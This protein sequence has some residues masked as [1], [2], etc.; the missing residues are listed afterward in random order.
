MTNLDFESSQLQL[1]TDA[2]RAGPGSPEWRAAMEAVNVTAGETGG[3]AGN[4]EREYKL[5]YAARERLASGRQYR[6]VRAGAGFTRKVFDAIEQEDDAAGATPRALPA[7]NLIAAV[8][9]LVILG[10]LAI[11]AWLIIPGDNSQQAANDLSQTY[12]V[13]K[14]AETTFDNGLGADWISF[15]KL[16]VEAKTGLRPTAV[17]VGAGDAPEKFLGGGATYRRAID[18]NQPFAVEASVRIPKISDAVVVQ[19]FVSDNASFEGD[20]ATT[21]RELAWLVRGTQASVAM[22]N[23]AVEFADTSVRA[24]QRINVRITANQADA[25]VEMNGKKLWS[26][27]NQL[28]PK[29]T[30]TVGVRFLVQGKPDEKTVPVVESVRVLVPQK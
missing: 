14:I 15:G 16:P 3:E 6:E 19:V 23:G 25:A 1:L 22:P 12:F 10:V 26:G 28:D 24:G 17:A 9:A 5:L 7:A 21:P 4:A 11:V 27:P 30:R 29:K 18:A 13:N 8:S 2:L 20:S